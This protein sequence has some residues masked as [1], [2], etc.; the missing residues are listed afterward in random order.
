MRIALDMGHTPASPG[1]R[2][3]LDELTEDRRI[4]AALKGSLQSRGHVVVDTT[5]PDGTAY[6]AEVDYRTRTANASGAE[7]F[8]SVHL[9]AGGGTGTEALYYSGNADGLAYAKR[10]SAA[11]ASTLGLPDRGPK[12]RTG[13]V[14]VIRDTSMTAVLVEVCFVDS[15]ADEAA[16]RASSPEAIAEAIAGAIGGESAPQP[17][18]PEAQPAEPSAPSSGAELDVDGLW[19]PATTLALQKALDAPYKDGIISRQQSA[20]RKYLAACVDGWE[21]GTGYAEGS[22]T[23]ELLQRKVGAPADGVMGPNTVRYL[24][25]HLGTFIDGYLDD[26]SPCVKEMQRRLNAGTF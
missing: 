6:P 2:G 5:P 21:W 24:Q 23:I 11:V 15:K 19:G 12:A 17:S 16:Y 20:Q 13:E 22:Q 7:L 9:N 14:G 25:K 26:P 18:Q 8:V 1:A 4:G 10:V 3:Y